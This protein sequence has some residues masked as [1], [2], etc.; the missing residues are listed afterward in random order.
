MPRR[1]R[2]RQV[3]GDE[4]EP[5]ELTDVG[6]RPHSQPE[7]SRRRVPVINRAAATVRLIEGLG[8]PGPSTSAARGLTRLGGRSPAEPAT[9]PRTWQVQPR[10]ARMRPPASSGLRAPGVPDK[11]RRG[12]LADAPSSCS[13]MPSVA[14]LSAVML[15]S[16]TGLLEGTSRCPQA[17][18]LQSGRVFGGSDRFL[19][20]S[21][22]LCV[23]SRCACHA[24]IRS[25]T[26][27]ET[28]RQCHHYACYFGPKGHSCASCR[29]DLQSSSVAFHAFARSPRACCTR[30]RRSDSLNDCTAGWELTTSVVLGAR[31]LGLR[32]S[33]PVGGAQRQQ[34]RVGPQ[35]WPQQGRCV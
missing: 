14:R 22:N 34:T 27:A 20:A 31:A 11:L 23:H 10:R 26:S 24:G 2:G 13:P 8:G 35:C 15:A 5:H 6:P 12:C 18:A 25:N 33:P 9:R 17:G 7:E 4:A 21:K 19:Q 16:T 32:R 29:K 28:P 1:R 3:R 30:A